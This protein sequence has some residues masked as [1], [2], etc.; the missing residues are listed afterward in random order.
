MGPSY[1]KESFNV[2]QILTG[3]EWGGQKI[4]KSADV[5]KY[6][7]PL[8]QVTHELMNK[9]LLFQWST[10]NASFNK[11]LIR[12]VAQVKISLLLKIQWGEHDYFSEHRCGSVRELRSCDHD[13]AESGSMR[14][15]RGEGVEI[16]IAWG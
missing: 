7:E 4:E 11:V 15:A 13:D 5:I 2:W 3:L 16:G 10:C 14:R 12:L 9:A 1:L 6:V 8:N